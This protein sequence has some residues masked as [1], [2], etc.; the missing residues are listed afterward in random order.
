MK[1][2]RLA[3]LLTGLAVSAV[4]AAVHDIQPGLTVTQGMQFSV[5]QGA[6]SY[7]PE[8]DA[9]VVAWFKADAISAT[10][11]EDIAVWPASTG[12]NAVMGASAKW[13]RYLT[14]QQNLLPGVYFTDSP[15]RSLTNHVG[16]VSVGCLWVVSKFTLTSN[17]YFA[18]DGIASGNRWALLLNNT[19]GKFEAYAGTDLIGNAWDTDWHIHKLVFNGASSSITLDDGEPTGGNAGSHALTGLTL[20][21]NYDQ[22]TASK[23]T[24]GEVILQNAVPD[25]E[26]STA[27]RAYLNGRWGIW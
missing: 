23:A 21:A 22:S 15:A 2:L 7:D 4:A 13:P 26:A 3:I 19:Q 8:D 6:A 17:W 12:S 1:Q 27:I 25:S 24:L 16:N 20:G 10:N 9:T 18:V 11:N 14:N 5:S